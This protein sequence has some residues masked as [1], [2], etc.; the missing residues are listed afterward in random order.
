MT[1]AVS[2]GLQPAR[3]DTSAA[4]RPLDRGADARAFF[5]RAAVW[6]E[7]PPVHYVLLVLLQL[8]VIWDDWKFRDLTS[9][10][11]ASYF[12]RA[13]GW[14]ESGT[15]DIVWSPLYTSYYGTLLLIVGDAASATWTHRTI[16]T[17]TTALLVLATMRQFLPPVAAWFVAAWWTM[18]E[19][20]FNV[21]YEVHVFAVIP[22]LAAILVATKLHGAWGRALTLAILALAAVLVRNEYAIAAMLFAGCCGL[23]ELRQVISLKTGRVAYVVRQVSIYTAP[24]VGVL[25]LVGFYYWRSFVKFPNDREYVG[26][27]HTLNICQ[28]YAVGYQQRYQDWNLSPWTQCQELMTRQFG[29]P[30][31]SLGAALQA[32]PSAMIEHFL[33][34]AELTPNGIQVALFNA[35][36][37]RVTP[38]FVP[39]PIARRP[40]LILSAVTLAII[41]IGCGLFLSRFGGWARRSVAASGWGWAVLICSV[42]VTMLVIPVERPRPEYIYPLTLLLMTMVGISASLMHA[43]L[44]DGVKR[45]TGLLAPLAMLGVL[46]VAPSYYANPEHRRPQVLLQEYQTLKPYTELVTHPT[47][48]FL[49]GDNSYELSQ[50]FGPLRSKWLSYEVLGQYSGSQSLDE[51]LTQRGVTLF[52][53]NQ[54]IYDR[55]RADP[56]AAPL[57][58]DPESVGWKIIGQQ[59]TGPSSWM[60]LE[61]VGS[62]RVGADFHGT[63][64]S[65]GRSEIGPEM[66]TM[67]GFADTHLTDGLM[68]RDDD[69]PREGNLS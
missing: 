22:L 29:A 52:F 67:P 11:T 38:D 58:S 35:M 65:A 2:I 8:K 41:A 36:A 13:A 21:H 59:S 1:G 33:W 54:R 53:V 23:C 26:L 5:A 46:I 24:L 57:L 64:G 31:P 18:L 48:V 19:P 47:T 25:L 68:L 9:G 62:A 28:V 43:I 37:G 3:R 69:S 66:P 61:R 51:Y 20:T 40:V 50:Y 49:K 32:N 12:G 4:L 60:L 44:P 45:V 63:I 27:K 16:I 56:G 17:F 15:V 6:F 14:A 34:N 42:C 39:V 30:L 7:H 10:D 55:L